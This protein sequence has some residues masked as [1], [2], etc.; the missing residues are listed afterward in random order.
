MVVQGILALI[1]VGLPV[2]ALAGMDTGHGSSGLAL[3]AA[4]L[5]ILAAIAGI[6]LAIFGWS[7][8]VAA[9]AVEVALLLLFGYATIASGAVLG[10]ILNGLTAAS[11]LALTALL[12]RS[13]PAE[14]SAS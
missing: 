6:A 8:R 3:L 10:R 5:P 7:A 9:L 13:R 2:L 1:F 11:A 12:L 4:V 14:A